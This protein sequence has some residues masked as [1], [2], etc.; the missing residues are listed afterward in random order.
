MSGSI[1]DVP[2]KTIDG[3]EK[4]MGE[5]K[6]KV[7]LI[8]NTASQCGFTNQ[9]EG[10]ED[11]YKTYK[12]RGFVVLG[13]PCNQFGGQEPGDENEIKNFCSMEYKI[14]FPMH[15]KIEVN[16]NGEHPLYKILKTTAP[17]A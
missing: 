9:Y 17:Q 10:L 8:V 5:Y 14:T 16:G 2:V 3:E 12:D 13:F 7:V 11:L 4:T 1:W 15:S 6:G